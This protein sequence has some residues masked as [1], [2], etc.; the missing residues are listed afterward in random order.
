[1]AVTLLGVHEHLM[2]VKMVLEHSLGVDYMYDE[3]AAGDAFAPSVTLPDIV[4]H[5]V[6]VSTVQISKL[7]K[8]RTC[9]LWRFVK[10]KGV[11]LFL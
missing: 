6:P 5:I 3:V 10:I 9:L 11:Y 4:L 2:G 7:F 1:M 8:T